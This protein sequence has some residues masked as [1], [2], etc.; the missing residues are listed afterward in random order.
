M[1]EILFSYLPKNC[2]NCGTRLREYR[3]D[4]KLVR[5]LSG[6]F[7]AVH[8]IMMCPR[9][10]REYR[11]ERLFEI[12]PK[13]CRYSND[14]MVESAIERFI[15]G[16]SCSEISRSLGM[17]ESHA[18]KMSNQALDI[19]RKIHEESA[20]K[21]AA[22]M[23]SYILQID[24]TVDSEFSMIVAVKDA[25]SGF[26][27]Y[28]RKCPSESQASI[29]G[30][31]KSV[32]DRFG[33]PSGITCDMRSGIISASEKIFPEVPVRICLMHFLRDLGKEL[34]LDLHTD[35]GIMINHMGIKSRLRTIMHDMPEYCES[36]LNEIDEGF[37]THRNTMEEMAI[38]RIL[39]ELF[40][41]GSSDYGFPFSLRHLN[42]YTSCEEVLRNLSELAPRMRH[43]SSINIIERIKDEI[44][45]VT[46]NPGIMRIA[47]QLKDINSAI[48]Q[49]IRGAFRIPESGDLSND[50]YDTSRDDPIV[51]EQC[52][53]VFGELEV[54][55]HANIEKHILRSAKLAI[56]RFSKRESMLFSQNREG[57]MKR[58]NNGM[59][60]LFRKVRRN[61]RK[62]CGNIA[63]GNV[64]AQ[65]GESLL[66][67]QNVD[68]QRY[69]DAVF[70]KED[71][72]EVFSRYRMP[73]KK[74]GMTR[75]RIIALV[76]KGTKMILEDHIPDSPYSRELMS[77]YFSNCNK[78]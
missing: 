1:K 28:A 33:T 38:K 4:R 32:K 40:R 74:E 35:L 64:I 22:A 55:L 56:D 46:D 43:E 10:K 27:L 16:K 8:R 60:I 36:T 65:S 78:G 12:V 75:K 9:E 61:V 57:T 47:H 73:F 30:V 62:R 6:E 58:T 31:M 42:F 25:L 2:P 21:L 7:T 51:H 39:E 68:N 77:E 29:E 34:M 70:G 54:Y 49:K 23:P 5:T 76:D 37:C 3:R 50:I 71:M 67:F 52:R 20:K 44:S 24:G 72:S 17:S 48:F 66:L 18:G 13:R 59:E 26:V 53:I 63:T 11:S 45:K 19:F 41:N 14:V 69:R 15:T